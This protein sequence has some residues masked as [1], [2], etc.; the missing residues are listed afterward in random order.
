MPVPNSFLPPESRAVVGQLVSSRTCAVTYFV[1]GIHRK[2]PSVSP[3][4]IVVERWTPRG[5]GCDVEIRYSYHDVR[6]DLF[7][8]HRLQ[9][10]W[11]EFG[12][13]SVLHCP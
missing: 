6:Y 7:L 13:P 3:A 11:S 5:S 1:I 9:G 10:D 12:G 8:E 2:W 4:A